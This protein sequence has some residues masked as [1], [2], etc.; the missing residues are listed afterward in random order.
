MLL[1][2]SSP[3]VVWPDVMQTGCQGPRRVP[4]RPELHPP[5]GGP[6]LCEALH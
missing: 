2:F 4:V 6:L 3:D 5:Q 1:C